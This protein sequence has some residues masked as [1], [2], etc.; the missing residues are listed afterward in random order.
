MK[1]K[2][3]A[4]LLACSMISLFLSCAGNPENHQLAPVNGASILFA[5]QTVDSILFYT[6]DSWSVTS[7]SDWITI[8]GQ[9]HGE[10]TYDYTKRYLC[11]VDVSLLPNTTGRTRR[12]LALVKS[13]D[14]SYSFPFYQLG[15][16]EVSHPAYTVESYYSE[17]ST[18][19]E[20]TS[21]VLTDSAHWTAD[22]ICFTVHNN[23]ELKPSDGAL[24]DWLVLEGATSGLPGKGEVRL[25]LTSNTDT[26]NERK[27][28]LQLTSGEVSNQITV[29]Q[30]PAKKGE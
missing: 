29:R 15:M 19:P 13:Y 24:P 28:T 26:E 30:L 9:S 22:S 18:L 12:G 23:W 10:F 17:S 1:H 14:Y 3:K 7:Q 6:F 5:D 25:T 11:R 2:T 20:V 8:E 4:L 16:L 21:F 27:A